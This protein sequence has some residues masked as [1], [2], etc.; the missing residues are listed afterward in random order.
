MSD[1]RYGEFADHRSAVNAVYRDVD[2]R[3]LDHVKVA[4]FHY[5]GRQGRILLRR[6]VLQ[7]LDMARR[8]LCDRVVVDLGRITHMHR[9]NYARC[10]LEGNFS[11]LEVL[12]DL[13]LQHLGCD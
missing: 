10:A 2:G 11:A 5:L 4:I 8:L 6:L 9:V 7:R 3:G 1:L 12:V 13:V